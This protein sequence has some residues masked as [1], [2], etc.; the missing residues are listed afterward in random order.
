LFG[1]LQPFFRDPC[2]K[3]AGFDKPPQF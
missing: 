1:R 3:K 2:F